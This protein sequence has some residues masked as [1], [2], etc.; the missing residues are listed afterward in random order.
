M[1]AARG[2]C[3]LRDLYTEISAGGRTHTSV[4][5]RVE[6]APKFHIELPQVFRLAVE[7]RI[8]IRIERDD[9]LRIRQ[10]SNG[11]EHVYERFVF[12]M[13]SGVQVD[14]IELF[15]PIPEDLTIPSCNRAVGAPAHVVRTLDQSGLGQRGLLVDWVDHRL[16]A[17]ALQSSV[18]V[19]ERDASEDVGF[20][21]VP[22]ETLTLEQR[23]GNS[24]DRSESGF[25]RRHQ[26]PSA[27]ES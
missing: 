1:S 4:K 26:V 20:K 11:E 8:I 14:P 15:P 5:A 19:V 23:H 25:Y 27:F 21:A 22:R 6:A 3:N 7:L 12:R 17:P 10:L 24:D 9:E 2:L 13:W 16:L 18:L